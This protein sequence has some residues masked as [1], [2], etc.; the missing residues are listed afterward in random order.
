MRRSLH[1][2]LL[3]ALAAASFLAGRATAPGIGRY[4]IV[5]LNDTR[6][7]RASDMTGVYR[8]DTLTGECSY[9]VRSVIGKTNLI[10]G[11]SAVGHLPETLRSI[12]SNS[13]PPQR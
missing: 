2:L 11:W 13:T 12:L 7:I 5:T 6:D 4:Q 10:E 3:I 9:L 1:F 8:I